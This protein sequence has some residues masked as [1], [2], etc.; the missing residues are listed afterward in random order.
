MRGNGGRVAREG[1]MHG[2]NWQQTDTQEGERGCA[3]VE[4]APQHGV[5]LCKVDW[6]ELLH[7]A[8]AQQRAR[9]AAKCVCVCVCGVGKCLSAVMGGRASKAVGL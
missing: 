8:L 9:P 7:Q 1:G 4:A 6:D 5:G 3:H 2:D